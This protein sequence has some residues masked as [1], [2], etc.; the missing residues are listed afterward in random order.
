MVQV[1]SQSTLFVF[2]L[3]GA[4][5]KRFYK[6]W[7]RGGLIDYIR[8]M[9]VFLIGYMG[10]GKT[11]VA[12]RLANAMGMDV[13]DLDGFIEGQE[14][15]TIHEIFEQE[16]ESGFRGVERKW[17]K[18]MEELDEVIISTGGGAP[19]FYDNMKVMNDL[20]ITVYLKMD[21]RSIVYRLMNAKEDRPLVRGKSEKEMLKFVYQNLEE[22]REFYEQC[23]IEVNALGFSSAKMEKLADAIVNYSR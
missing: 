13:V 12:K 6:Y 10:V 1:I 9:R 21:P 17:L 15:R 16:G 22:R 2:F 3:V 7:G 23:Q 14:N 11:T 19:C 4:A 20:G 8:P 5:K 18:E